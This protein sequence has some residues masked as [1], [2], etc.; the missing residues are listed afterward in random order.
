MARRKDVRQRERFLKSLSPER[1]DK[2]MSQGRRIHVPNQIGFEATNLSA[3]NATP[4][5]TMIQLGGSCRQ[6]I[7]GGESKL[8][9]CAR[10]IAAQLAPA[11]LDAAVSDIA[12]RAF[13]IALALRGNIEQHENAQN[14]LAA[15]QQEQQEPSPVIQTGE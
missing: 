4:A 9:A 10:E 12:D 3:P 1:R 5:A 15:A 14:K 6:I 2:L 8:D 11:M 13:A 7:V